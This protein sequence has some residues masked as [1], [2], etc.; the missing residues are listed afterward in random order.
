MDAVVYVR[1]SKDD[2]ADDDKD[3]RKAV[4]R[5]RQDAEKMA[6]I[7]GWTVVEVVEDNDTSAT[8]GQPRPGFERLLR[9]VDERRVQV[10]VADRWDRLLRNRKDQYRLMELGQEREL[11]VSLIKGTDVDMSTAQGRLVAGI[12]G[13]VA[14]SESEIAKERMRRFFTQ[15]AAEGKPWWSNR[16]Y[17]YERDGTLRESEAALIRDAYDRVLHGDTLKDIARDI[18]KGPSH[19]RQILCAARNAG[20]RTHNGEEVGPGNWTP[21]VSED[22]WRDAVAVL[23]SPG[24]T[25]GGPRR[26]TYLLSTLAWCGICDNGA[27]V[28]SVNSH[29][30]RAY[31]CRE[32][33]HCT[34]KAADIEEHVVLATL[35]TLAHGAG[36]SIVRQSDPEQMRE[37]RGERIRL[38]VEL[39][40]LADA[41]GKGQI[42]LSQLIVASSGLQER[43][44]AIDAQIHERT[45]SDLLDGLWH[46][47]W[48]DAEAR[49][50][51]IRRF[52]ELP[53]MRRQDVL[54]SVWDRITLLP[55]RPNQKFRP[56]TVV[57]RRAAEVEAVWDS[58]DEPRESGLEITLG[59]VALAPVRVENVV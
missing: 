20:I 37:L 31:R 4:K 18:G 1:I 57:F 45:R 59:E 54:R 39:D 40:E 42:T 2:L 3:G 10:V 32:K 33:H 47:T 26:L 30:N 7:K 29:G 27:T 35:W 44:D 49:A 13:E 51:A 36:E 9:L 38:G 17:G 5:Q 8:K 14:T 52:N 16:P 12:L 15:H 50:E 28:V 53:L 46:F 56:E 48:E 34:R 43:V 41:H 11:R 19:L 22:T 6:E 21:L 55:I 58:T 24:R 23:N 25:H